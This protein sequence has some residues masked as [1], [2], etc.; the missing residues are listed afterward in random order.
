MIK[1]KLNLTPNV[2]LNTFKQIKHIYP[3]TYAADNFVMPQKQKENLKKN[4]NIIIKNIK[5][6]KKYYNIQFAVQKFGTTF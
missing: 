6:I 4:K 2:F 5:N 1:I 3:H